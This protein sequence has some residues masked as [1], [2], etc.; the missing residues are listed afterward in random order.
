VGKKDENRK[1][2]KPFFFGN[3]P[4]TFSYLI[5]HNLYGGQTQHEK[6]DI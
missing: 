5:V 4:N 1:K 2:N 3:R 6:G